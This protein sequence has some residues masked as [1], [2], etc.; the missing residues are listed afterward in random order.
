MVAMKE[1]KTRIEVDQFI[2]RFNFSNKI[3]L[4]TRRTTNVILIKASPVF[5]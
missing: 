2:Y 5:Q 3:P 4:S 1:M